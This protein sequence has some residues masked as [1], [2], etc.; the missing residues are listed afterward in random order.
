MIASRFS[1]SLTLPSTSP[2][3]FIGFGS[4]MQSK[5]TPRSTPPHTTTIS[6][7]GASSFKSPPKTHKLPTICYLT[8]ALPYLH[9]PVNRS[10]PPPWY[11][12]LNPLPSPT[13]PHLA[14]PPSPTH[15]TL[16]SPI[17]FL[18]SPN[19]PPRPPSS[20]HM[21]PLRPTSLLPH[22]ATHAPP[23]PTAPAP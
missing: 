17:L 22:P 23:Y 11:A 19:G 20:L 3:L 6:S 12:I 5:H 21:T 4:E 2:G 16:P 9:H 10:L 13:L 1:F 7:Y 14:C 18:P 8:L 15:S